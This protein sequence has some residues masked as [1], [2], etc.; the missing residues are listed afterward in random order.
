MPNTQCISFNMQVSW[1]LSE[2]IFLSLSQ[3]LSNPS[4]EF[5]ILLSLF[6]ISYVK[7]NEPSEFP[8]YNVPLLSYHIHSRCFCN[9]KQSTFH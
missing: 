5:Y 2:Q 7:T 3:L 9:P 4:S 8:P 6:F 1:L